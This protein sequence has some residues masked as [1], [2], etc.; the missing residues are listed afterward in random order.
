VGIC[1]GCHAGCCRTFAVPVTGADIIRIRRATGLSFW[2]FVC[3]WADSDHQI[4]KDVV[5]HF[6][7]PDQPAM[8]FV[9]ALAHA[10]S[11]IFPG[12]TK[13]RFLLEGLPDTAHP[14]G[15][16]RCCIYLH[17]PMACRAFPAKLNE[18]GELAELQSV[19]GHAR[20]EAVAVYQLCPRPW[21]PEDLDP[22]ETPQTLAVIRYEMAFFHNVARLWNRQPQP[23]TAF[24]D[25]LDYVYSRRILPVSA[26]EA[27]D[28][29]PVIASLPLVQPR[30]TFRAKA[31]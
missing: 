7:F 23:W 18:T 24:P 3:R 25:F 28:T 6:H 2:D 30:T 21:E 14:L 1:D 16:G 15:Q 12:T 31:A 19:P 11:P 26:D 4:A 20:D 22:V 8:P 29:E 13:C 9:I 27:P 5:P 17:R 10:A